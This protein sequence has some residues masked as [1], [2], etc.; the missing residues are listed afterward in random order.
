MCHFGQLHTI[1]KAYIHVSALDDVVCY[2]L[3]IVKRVTI[4]SH[5]GEISIFF[6]N[7]PIAVMTRYT[8]S[9][10]LCLF[11]VQ[12]K[13]QCVDIFCTGILRQSSNHGLISWNYF[14]NHRVNVS[15]WTF[16]YQAYMSQHWMRAYTILTAGLSCPSD[17]IT[18]N[19]TYGR[20][21]WWKW[22]TTVYGTPNGK[23]WHK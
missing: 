19:N 18:R 20:D 5:F 4:T 16:T 2:S 22:W 6:N 17:N 9:K 10:D 14:A 21:S 13:Y 11:C 1:G 3:K 8:C 15:L 23:S 7:H 12:E